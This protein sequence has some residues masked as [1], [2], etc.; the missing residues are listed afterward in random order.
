MRRIRVAYA[1]H[2]GRRLRVA[3]GSDTV[4]IWFAFGPDTRHFW[5]GLGSR[6]CHSPASGDEFFAKVSVSIQPNDAKMVF[7]NVRQDRR[8]ASEWMPRG[9]RREV[10]HGEPVA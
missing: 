7:M 10:R 5:F 3:F 2:T 4:R 6:R 9:I 1:S 8:C